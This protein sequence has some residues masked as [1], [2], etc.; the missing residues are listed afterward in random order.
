MVEIADIH[1][2]LLMKSEQQIN[3]AK[4]LGNNYHSLEKHC[5]DFTQQNSSEEDDREIQS[6]FY[7]YKPKMS[8]AIGING[9]S[10]NGLF[11]F[12]THI[13]FSVKFTKINLLMHLTP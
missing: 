1:N 4:W 7:L 11:S 2:H 12:S 8:K 6:S 5:I 3:S 10:K 9:D 13:W